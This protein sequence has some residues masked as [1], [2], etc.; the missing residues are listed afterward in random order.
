M[1]RTLSPLKALLWSKLRIS[2]HTLAAVRRQSKLKIAFVSAGAVFLWILIFVGSAFGFRLFEIFGAEVLEGARLTV[3]DL[4]M[5]RLLAVFALAL[6]VFLTFS[7]VLVAYATLYRARE[8]PFLVISPLPV[9]TFFLG[10]FAEVLSFS[11]W[12]SAY[13]GSPVMLAYGIMAGA[14]LAFYPL[15]LAFYLPF[16]IIPAALGTVV[17]MLLVR[18]LPLL[19]RGHWLT[20]GTLLIAAFFL[21]FRGKVEVPDLSDSATFQAIIETMGSTQ[22]VFLPSYWMSQ[23]V[24]SAALGEVREAVFFFLVLLANALFALWLATR[25]AEVLFFPGFSGLESGGAVR[26]RPSRGPLRFADALLKPLPEPTRSLM[27]KD[28]KLFWRDPAQ[29][30]QFVLFFGIMALYVANLGDAHGFAQRESWSAW[31]TL[32][33][34]A[35]SMLI[36][37]SLTT[38]FV[39]PLISLEGPRIWILGLAPVGLRR[40]VWQKFWLSVGTTSI[41]TVTLAVLSAVQLE[42]GNVDFALSLVAT[43]GATVALSGLSVGLG[44]L[45]PNF[46]EDNPSRVVSGMGGTLNFLLS[47]LYVVLVSVALGL[48]L[49]WKPSW[50]GLFGDRAALAAGATGWIMLLTVLACGVPMRLGMRHLERAEF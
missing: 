29:W 40:I 25:A 1:P 49:L 7:N 30:A 23:G 20:L 13:L 26:R 37:A 14:P 44:S 32:L 19:R 27:I 4:I 41:F 48:V 17:A 43:G 22:S 6:F 35:A 18:V 8:I 5:S 42:L 3:S 47:M 24:L 28:V 38:R 15:L 10:R 31:A 46:E 36:L 39:Y 33:N 21:Y 45:Y 16:I 2:R 12:A 50:G 9:S 11:S 34:L